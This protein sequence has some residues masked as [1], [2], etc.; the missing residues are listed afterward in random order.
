MGERTIYVTDFDLKR[1]SVGDHLLCSA[2]HNRCYL[3]FRIM[4]S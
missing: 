2:E 1:L 4:L 3:Q